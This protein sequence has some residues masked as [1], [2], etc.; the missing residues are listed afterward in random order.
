LAQE[1]IKKGYKGWIK[2]INPFGDSLSN[3]EK[4]VAEKKES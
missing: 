1:F 2:A 4:K 3:G